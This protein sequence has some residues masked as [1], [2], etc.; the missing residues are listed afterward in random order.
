MES[1]HF[2]PVA[3]AIVYE[4]LFKKWNNEK[5]DNDIVVEN[6]EKVEHILDFYEKRLGEQQYIG[7]NVFSI[8]DISHVP[9]IIYLVKSGYKELFKK[10]PKVYEWVKRITKRE[11]VK[12]MMN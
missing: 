12:K 10:R 9:Y 1:R 5:A 7:G 11:S 6:L 4:K 2:D 8:A 3:G